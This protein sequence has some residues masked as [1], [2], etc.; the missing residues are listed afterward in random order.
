MNDDFFNAMDKVVGKPSIVTT[1]DKN[2]KVVEKK[3]KNTINTYDT[4]NIK[5]RK[6]N[7]VINEWDENNNGQIVQLDNISKFDVQ[8]IYNKYKKELTAQMY[9]ILKSSSKKYHFSIS[10]LLDCPMKNFYLRTNTT[11]DSN[12]QPLYPYA[13]AGQRVGNL[14]HGEIQRTY[15]FDNIE[16][17]IDNKELGIT[18]RIDAIKDDTIYEI[19]K[20]DDLKLYPSFVEQACL[21]CYLYNKEHD[22][23]IDYFEIILSLSNLKKIE[24][25]KF[26]YDGAA[27]N[28]AIYKINNIN[29]INKALDENDQT[30]LKSHLDFDKCIFCPYT[31]RCSNENLEENKK[32]ENL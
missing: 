8:V 28:M 5:K 21:Y 24:S 11:F 2:D 17:K 23:V 25:F 6:Y 30:I 3:K 18:G 22:D 13:I 4:S 26:K 10:E 32:I 15:N 12:F 31:N 16:I 7:N 1:E 19:K 29:Y 20:S 14:T 9:S 27:K